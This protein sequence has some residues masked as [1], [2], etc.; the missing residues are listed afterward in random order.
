[1]QGSA[2]LNLMIKAARKAGRGSGGRPVPLDSDEGQVDVLAVA[3]PGAA[4]RDLGEVAREFLRLSQIGIPARLGAGQV[5][6][7]GHFGLMP[8]SPA[9]GRG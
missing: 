7:P 2:N 8:L 1:M 5:L 9:P 3:E 6:R 4:G